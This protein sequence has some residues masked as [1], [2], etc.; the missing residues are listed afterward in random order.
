LPPFPCRALERGLEH[1]PSGDCEAHSAGKRTLASYALRHL[2]LDA[3]FFRDM[4]VAAAFNRCI[5]HCLFQAGIQATSG[6]TRLVAASVALARG[7]LLGD[8]PCLG[9]W[10][11]AST[12]FQF[13]HALYGIVGRHEVLGLGVSLDALLSGSGISRY[14]WATYWWGLRLTFVFPF[15][16]TRCWLL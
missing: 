7:A 10:N 1:L 3:S 8:V 13:Y 12:H 14:D 11:S 4:L 5:Q 16:F 2:Q 9:E 6:S 15:S